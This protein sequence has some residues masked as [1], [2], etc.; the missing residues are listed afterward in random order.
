MSDF[1]RQAADLSVNHGQVVE[2]YRAAHA[3]AP[4]ARTGTKLSDTE[5]LRRAMQGTIVRFLSR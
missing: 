1:E 5:E 3:I 2:N 4:P